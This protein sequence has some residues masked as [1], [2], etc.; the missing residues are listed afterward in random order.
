M[1]TLIIVVHVIICLAVIGL[2]LIQDSKGGALG[3]AW[4]G[5]GANSLFGP[6]GASTLAQ[7]VTRFFAILF[8][9]SCI[10]LTV[11]FKKDSSSV[12]DTLPA[13]VAKPISTSADTNT[14]NGQTPT[15]TTT[16][17]N[18]AATNTNTTSTTITK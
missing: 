5:G 13:E 8:A 10:I 14:N 4:G 11:Y 2:V 17:A 3:S 15:A 18:A 16:D 7:K 12:I 6:M 1:S 9:V